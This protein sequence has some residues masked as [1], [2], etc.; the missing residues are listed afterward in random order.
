[1]GKDSSI[2]WTT[3]TYNPWRGCRK[4]SA[5]CAYCYMFTEQGRRGIDPT[6]VT[7]ARQP[8]F[9]SPLRWKEP[10]FVFTCSYSDFFIEEADPW[11]DEAWS[12]IRQTPHL[13]YQMLTKR[14]EN[15]LDRLPSD[16]GDGYENVWLLVSTENQAMLDKRV[17]ILRE[18]PARLH[19]ISAEPLLEL[20]D[21]TDYLGYCPECGSH[22]L[23][24]EGW[25]GGIWWANFKGVKRLQHR[26][27]GTDIQA[28][29]WGMPRPL[30]WVIV[31]GES[32]PRARE[33]KLSW[34]CSIVEQCRR[35]KTAVFVKQLGQKYASDHGLR[36]RKGQD[37]SEWPEELRVREMPDVPS[38]RGVDGCTPGFQPGGLGSIPS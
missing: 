34:L 17:P 5:G 11:R 23:S 7:R 32:G 13:T 25:W 27:E 10:A 28:G 22:Y 26:C 37:P 2:E 4:V 21:L 31:G 18:I 6:V 20:L 8:T 15:I 12:I 1:M 3:H 33:V 16:W 29:R 24:T 36:Q 30:N 38:P 9:R 35:A 19:G 14:P